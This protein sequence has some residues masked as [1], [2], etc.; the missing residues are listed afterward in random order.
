MGLVS[1]QVKLGR[2]SLSP[3][4]VRTQQDHYLQAKRGTSAKQ[5]HDG[6]LSQS[7][8][9]PKMSEI[10]G[11]CFSHPLYGILLQ[12]AKWT[13]AKNEAKKKISPFGRY[14]HYFSCHPL[15]T[16]SSLIYQYSSSNVV[17]RWNTVL[18]IFVRM[19]YKGIIIS[20]N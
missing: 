13:K 14:V 6:T 18:Q 4:Y 12:Q 1:L 3:C 19:E 20:C 5:N 10:K 7:F 8:Q 11:Y 9:H 17:A 2:D 16:I 15:D